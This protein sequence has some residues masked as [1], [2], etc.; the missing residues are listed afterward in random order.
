MPPEPDSVHQDVESIQ[1]RLQ[2]SLGPRGYQSC[3]G[4]STRLEIQG[5]ELIIHVAVPYLVKWIQQRYGK[6]VNEAV[7]AV[8][9]PA[10]VARYEIGEDVVLTPDVSTIDTDTAEPTELRKSGVARVTTEPTVQP[11]RRF[12]KRLRTLGDFVVGS[13]NELAL[14]AVQQVVDD[15]G[16]V[17]PLYLHSSIG[18]GKSHLL[19]AIRLRLRKEAA[20]LQVA[21]LTAEQFANYF[22][23]ALS[24]KTLPSFRQRFRSVDV[25]LVDDVDFFDGKKAIQEEFLHTVKQFEEAGRQLVVTGNRHPRLLG[26]SSEELTSRFASGLVCRIEKP[27]LETRIE[28]V[29]RHAKRQ[30]CQLPLTTVEFIASKFTTNGR[31]LEGAVNILATWGQM[32]KKRV[33]VTSARKLLSQLERDCMRIVRLADIENAVCGLFGVEESQLKSK[34]RKQ[35]ISQPRMLAMY[36]SRKLTQTPYS[37]IGQYYGGRNHSTV[38]SAEKKID[39]QLQQQGQIRI[40][41]ETWQLQ[42]LLDT[43][44]DRIQAG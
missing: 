4:A 31:E 21:L 15:P 32:T 37:E 35:S 25:L 5:A 30:N 8:I 23:Q 28:I 14:T 12:G 1:Q 18:N 24:A 44:K 9:G 6:H 39:N 40:A 17:T 19:E 22:T 20:H 33:T 27:D 10:G 36:L 16:S 43:L 13:S 26:N 29:H 11:K 38:M 7:R 34:T 3:F 41:S 42:D 2:K